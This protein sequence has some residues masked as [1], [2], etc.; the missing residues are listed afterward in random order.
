MNIFI[1]SSKNLVTY[2]F[3]LI[4]KLDRDTSQHT[5]H[6]LQI[7]LIVLSLA[8]QIYISFCF[9]TKHR[10]STTK[11][12]PPPFHTLFYVPQEIL[13]HTQCDSTKNLI[14]FLFS[15]LSAFN[16]TFPSPFI[17]GIDGPTGTGKTTIAKSIL[18]LFREADDRA[19][20]QVETV[21]LDDFYRTGTDIYAFTT[22]PPTLTFIDTSQTKE[23]CCSQPKFLQVQHNLS[24]TRKR[25]I[26]YDPQGNFVSS[27]PSSSDGLSAMVKAGNW[28]SLDSIDFN[29]YY[30]R[31]HDLKTTPTPPQHSL[32]LIVTEGFRLVRSSDDL[33]HFH[34]IVHLCPFD[35][36]PPNLSLIPNS[37]PLSLFLRRV[38]RDDSQVEADPDK[39]FERAY[40]LSVEYWN[41]SVAPMIVQNEAFIHQ[42]SKCTPNRVQIIQTRRDINQFSNIDVQSL[43]DEQA[44][45]IVLHILIPAIFCT[46]N[47]ISKQ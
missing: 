32:R 31:L 19:S 3:D 8:S 7:Q 12:S 30:T 13:S 45:C 26:S 16:L 36:I 2:Y 43:L 40:P 6:L 24:D 39:E 9:V 37:S 34:Q 42:I 20:T 18:R 41:S 35:E 25:M 17:F 11:V 10:N 46:F 38:W 23:S 47:P 28:D 44:C 27:P 5:H 22:L 33:S 14:S 21:G 4:T 1:L 29:R 15:S